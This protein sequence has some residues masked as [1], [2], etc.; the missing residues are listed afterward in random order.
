MKPLF[1]D[2]DFGVEIFSKYGIEVT[3]KS[4]A[5]TAVAWN[6]EYVGG[7]CIENFVGAKAEYERPFV[8]KSGENAQNNAGNNENKRKL[9]TKLVMGSSVTVGVKTGDHIKE[10]QEHTK[11]SKKHISQ[12]KEGIEKKKKEFI[13]AENDQELYNKIFNFVK[14]KKTEI[15][16]NKIQNLDT[17]VKKVNMSE[18]FYNEFFEKV[19][20]TY[21]TEINSYIKE[22][23]ELTEDVKEEINKIKSK[24]ENVEK[25]A[26]VV[27]GTLKIIGGNMQKIRKFFVNTSESKTKINSVVTIL[28][29]Q[30]INIKSKD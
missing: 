6:F 27:I 15:I 17:Y 18:N 1:D 8:K 14:S 19:T 20:D 28:N 10:V 4:E 23:E 30:K 13:L 24:I 26:E 29:A 16:N 7:V 25:K 22:V 3:A 11:I 21:K 9:P 5:K 2:N 12:I